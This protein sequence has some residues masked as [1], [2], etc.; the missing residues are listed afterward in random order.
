MKGNQ[1]S[2]EGNRALNRKVE[3]KTAREFEGLGDN[4]Y[5]NCSSND[6]LCKYNVWGAGIPL[7]P[8]ISSGKGW[9]CSLMVSVSNRKSLGQKDKP[10]K[11]PPRTLAVI[12]GG[13]QY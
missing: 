13:K 4:L 7:I 1:H 6:T 10:R 5:V 11:I 8:E 12:P 2:T 3:G 9:R